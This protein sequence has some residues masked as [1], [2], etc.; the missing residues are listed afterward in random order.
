MQLEKQGEAMEVEQNNTLPLDHVVAISD[1]IFGLQFLEEVLDAESI[2]SRT[3]YI[4]MSVVVRESYQRLER[5]R[6]YLLDYFTQQE[7]ASTH[8]NDNVSGFTSCLEG[9]TGTDC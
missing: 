4:G 7:K 2:L 5:A 9:R 1:I 3:G 6:N 8:S